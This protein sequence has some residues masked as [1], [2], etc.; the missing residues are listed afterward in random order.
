MAEAAKKYI[1][2]IER[3][4]AVLRCFAEHDELGLTEISNMIGLHKSTT[5]GIVNTLK[6]EK[7]LEQNPRNAKFKLGI[8]LF[9]LGANIKIDLKKICAPYLQRIL[10][11]TEETVNLVTYD[12]SDVIFIEKRE[13]PHSMRI[14]TSI[15]KRLPMYCTATG[16][17]ILA[18]LPEDE[19]ENLMRGMQITRFTAHTIPDRWTLKEQ[20]EVIREEKCSFDREEL[21]DG[22]VCIGA[23]ILD[24]SGRP[25][26]GVSVSGPSM[27]MTDAK[28]REIKRTLIDT[29]EQISNEF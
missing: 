18:N 15:G 26:G 8:E 12:G 9:R 28:M 27:R 3:A 20:L 6:N 24:R 4:A 14:C 10:D 16:K 1:Q 7:F 17:A 29:V 11:M 13:S 21:E 22:L 2:S 19:A 25:V 23:A 5:A